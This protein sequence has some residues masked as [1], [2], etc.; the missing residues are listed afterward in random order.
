MGRALSWNGLFGE[1]APNPI[2][3]KERPF[4]TR[5]DDELLRDLAASPD[6]LTE[7]EAAARLL[8]YG[9]NLAVVSVRRGLLQN[10]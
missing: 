3:R 5:I 6:G 4:W 10:S 9:P 7:S 8:H 1:A 2:A